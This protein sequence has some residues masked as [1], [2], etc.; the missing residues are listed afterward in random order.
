MKNYLEKI[1]MRLTDSLKLSSIQKTKRR[2]ET[3]YVKRLGHE[4]LSKHEETIF[5]KI[6]ACEAESFRTKHDL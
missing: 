3:I 6:H 5:K 2:P 1:Y 4:Q